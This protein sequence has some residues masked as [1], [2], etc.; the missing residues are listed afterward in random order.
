MYFDAHAHLSPQ[1]GPMLVQAER[2][3]VREVLLNAMDRGDW[4]TLIRLNRQNP[5]YHI[6]LGVHPDR[7]GSLTPGWND[8]LD[9]ALIQN[10]TALVGEI[11]LDVRYP[12]LEQQESA[13]WIQLNLAAR[14][15]RPAVVHCYG[16]WKR[17]FSVLDSLPMLPPKIMSH[18]HHGQP[19]Q[20]PDLIR[21]YNM[22]FSYSAIVLPENHPKI[23]ACLRATPDNR[24]MIESDAPDLAPDIRSVIKLIPEIAAVRNEPVK[25]L[26]QILYQNTREFIR[27]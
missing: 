2:A 5:L 19:E 18:S 9:Q 13:L 15:H 14:Y 7:V 21:K 27:C 23:R 12:D 11:G 3:G 26:K 25:H 20:I 16:A 1:I 4:D 10:P 24:L 17:L 8:Q 6:A 22:Y